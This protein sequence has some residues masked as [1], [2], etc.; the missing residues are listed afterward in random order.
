MCEATRLEQA[1][2]S[3]DHEKFYLEDLLRCSVAGCRLA[4][5][6]RTFDIQ[7]SVSSLNFH[8]S[9]E[10]FAQMLDK[11]IINVVEFSEENSAINLH[12]VNSDSGYVFIITNQG[13]LLPEN[14]QH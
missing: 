6:T 12:M 10:L 1:I 5:A 11:I 3:S 14:I 2:Q 7:V 4:H 9:P 13:D 8:G